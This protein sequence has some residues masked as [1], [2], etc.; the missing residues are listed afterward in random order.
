MEFNKS[1][2]LQQFYVRN[3]NLKL[4]NVILNHLLHVLRLYTKNIDSSYL[5]LEV[6]RIDGNIQWKKYN[7]F[8]QKYH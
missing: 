4:E 3:E 2:N 7:D 5:I 6:F 8:F 1:I